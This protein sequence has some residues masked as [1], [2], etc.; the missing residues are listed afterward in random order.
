VTVVGEVQQKEFAMTIVKTISWMFT[1]ASLVGTI[2]FVESGSIKSAAITALVA[3]SLKTPM[4]TL[5]E[6]LW[7]RIK[8]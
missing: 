1:S 7:N 8:R 2:A 3:A 4:Y 5:H 6:V